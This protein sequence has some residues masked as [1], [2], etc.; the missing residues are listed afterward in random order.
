MKA[1]SPFSLALTLEV[2]MKKKWAGELAQWLRVLVVL[3]KDPGLFPSMHLKTHHL[4]G[5]QAQM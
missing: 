3:A 4:L 1:F 2:K 5:H